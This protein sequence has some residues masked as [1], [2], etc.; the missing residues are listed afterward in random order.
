MPPFGPPRRS[1]SLWRLL[2]LQQHRHRCRGPGTARHG[3]LYL[4]RHGELR[5][6]V[7]DESHRIGKNV[8]EYNWASRGVGVFTKMVGKE[9]SALWTVVAGERFLVLDRVYRYAMTGDGSVGFISARNES[10]FAFF[11]WHPSLARDWENTSMRRRRPIL[12]EVESLQAGW[13]GYYCRTF[14]PAELHRFAD[15]VVTPIGEDLSYLADDPSGRVLCE[16]RRGNRSLHDLAHRTAYAVTDGGRLLTSAT[17]LLEGLK[18]VAVDR[19]GQLVELVD[20][21]LRLIARRGSHGMLAFFAFNDRAQYVPRVETFAVLEKDAPI[22][23]R[24]DRRRL[25]VRT[26]N[27]NVLVARDVDGFQVDLRDGKT[28]FTASG[29]LRI[30]YQGQ[31]HDVTD[32]G[33][34]YV[35]LVGAR[36]LYVDER[37][38]LFLYAD[39]QSVAL[40]RDRT[41]DPASLTVASG[42]F[43]VA[44]RAFQGYMY[45]GLKEAGL[46][47]GRDVA[48]VRTVEGEL[49]LLRKQTTAE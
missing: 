15:G 13:G 38:N 14:R 19:N 27:E 24:D 7:G 26:G 42:N 49:Y 31:I 28:V 40:L 36:L 25:Y 44:R 34:A 37:R 16:D 1:E 35:P 41:I 23:F 3:R 20:G 5:L 33:N 48:L 9:G 46:A 29:R 43:P 12:E 8:A 39:G 32:A 11:V 2:L 21:T 6:A 10:Q 18:V 22:A 17:P 47:Q 45:D 30:L 4:E